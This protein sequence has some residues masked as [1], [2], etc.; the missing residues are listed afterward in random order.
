[1]SIDTATGQMIIFDPYAFYGHQEIEL[2]C[3][4]HN[5]YHEVPGGSGLKLGKMIRRYEEVVR[6]DEPV[7][8][9]ED[10][11]RLSAA[12]ND[13]ASGGIVRKGEREEDWRG[14]LKGEFRFRSSL[15]TMP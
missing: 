7:D 1:M 10:K 15:R 13:I 2:Q 3:W 14:I 4:A 6:A 11:V 12:R 9:F 8:D 5:R